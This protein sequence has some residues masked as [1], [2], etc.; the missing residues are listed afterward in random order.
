MPRYDFKCESEEC[1]KVI[2]L[3]I[4]LANYESITKALIEGG[5]LVWI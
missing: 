2:E 4:K 1:G 3:S 5:R